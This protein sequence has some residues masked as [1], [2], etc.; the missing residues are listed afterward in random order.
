[1]GV[2]L[3]VVLMMGT[4]I[5]QE[6]LTM[7]AAVQTALQRNQT[8]LGAQ[9]D[10][11]ASRWGRLNAVSNF[12]PKVELGGGVTRI[13]AASERRANASIDFIK[14]AAGALGIPSEL[15]S[16]IKPFAYRDTYAAD[17]TVVQPIYNGGAEIAGLSAANAMED[18]SGFALQDAEHDV[19]SRVKTSY[20]NVL[21]ADELVALARD[22]VARTKR[23]LD[24]TAR[25]AG[26]GMRTRTD[27]LRWEVQ[28]ASDEGTLIQAENGLAGTR[29]ELNEAMGVDLYAAYTLE[30][31]AMPDSTQPAVAAR[32]GETLL[33]SR[34]P[35][36]LEAGI[37][38]DI[39]AKHPSM[40]MMEAN[41]RLADAGIEQAWV[42]FKPRINVAFQYGWEKNNTLKLDGITP[43]ALALQVRFPIFNSFGDY[44]NLQKAH[45]EYSRTESRVESF[46]R[47]LVLQATMAGFNVR[48]AQKRIDITR[49]AEQEA[50]DVLDSVTLRYENG[51][52]SNVDLIDVQTAYTSARV[53]AITAL[54][55]YH[56]A[57]V[58]QARAMGTVQPN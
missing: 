49:K 31:P 14:G 25:R 38:A 30:A 42:N 43:W 26:V 4:A 17:I 13:D 57:R 3:A 19:I 28:L 27:V 12:L 40:R 5:G 11:D 6:Q 34:A 23:H 45:A 55:D 47:G 1:M 56:I 44:T 54:Y 58:Q 29:L 39:L 41:L 37:N 33:A 24:M 46:R 2:G 16:E 48:A 22:A 51:G 9:Y 35:V 21:K 15:L 7:D 32:A 20:L 18:R 10:R 50:R 52:A 53:N 8:L 36:S